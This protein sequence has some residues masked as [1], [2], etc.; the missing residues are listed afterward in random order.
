MQVAGMLKAAKSHSALASQ[1]AA[2][3]T[4]ATR[5]QCLE[6]EEASR[7]KKTTKEALRTLEERVRQRT[8]M[9]P[10]AS[11][12]TLAEGSVGRVGSGWFLETKAKADDGVGGGDDEED[13]G[14]LEKEE[15]VD[16]ASIV[17]IMVDFVVFIVVAFVD[18]ADDGTTAAAAAAAAADDDEYKDFRTL[19]KED[20]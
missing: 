18:D 4:P 2:T 8:S 15:K 16:F 13:G 9:R 6:E 14:W 1:Y 11:W 19:G 20:K 7:T 5:W 12:A 17:F 10:A 3:E